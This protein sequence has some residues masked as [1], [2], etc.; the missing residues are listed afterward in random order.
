MIRFRRF[1]AFA[2][3]EVDG[4]VHIYYAT[5][6]KPEMVGFVKIEG[7][8]S[9]ILIN[10]K[11]AKTETQCL[12]V[13]CHELSHVI[14]GLVKHNKP[15]IRQLLKKASQYFNISIEVLKKEYEKIEGG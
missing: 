5:D 9:E 11:V 4:N 8:T 15:L 13:L 10:V 6:L 2:S 3:R 12:C 14:S 7:N 1:D